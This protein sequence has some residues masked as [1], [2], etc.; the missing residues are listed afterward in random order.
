MRRPAISGLRLAAK[1]LRAAVAACSRSSSGGQQ[2]PAH[3]AGWASAGRLQGATALVSPRATVA[4]AAVA[5]A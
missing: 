5:G 3:A 2:S 4:A 1:L